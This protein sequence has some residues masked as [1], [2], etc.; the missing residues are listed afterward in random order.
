M[1]EPVYDPNRR[2]RYEFSREGENL[3]V[4]IS[5][6]SGGDVPTHFH[7]AQEER[8]TVREG[9]VRFKV[10]GRKVVP[11]PGVE[12]TVAPGVKHSFKNIGD[13]EALI[14]AEVRP[15]LELQ[16]FLEDGA[17][18]ARAGY[19]SRRGIIKSR[20]GLVKMADF[21][22]RYRDVTVVTFPPRVIQ[23]ALIMLARK[24]GTAT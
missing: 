18:L 11:A 23:R 8:W 10:G 14:R 2:Q 9:R 20:I 12:L 24:S 22:D 13:G 6:A 3:I 19:Y 4:E 17:K 16:S 21:I 7:P 1:I 15:A 5:V